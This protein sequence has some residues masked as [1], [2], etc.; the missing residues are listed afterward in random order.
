[1]ENLFEPCG[2]LTKTTCLEILKD[3]TN[4]WGDYAQALQLKTNKSQNIIRLNTLLNAKSGLCREDCGY[5]AQSKK[6]LQRLKHMDYYPK[7]K[8]FVKR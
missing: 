4:L 5:C 3:K 8:S 6:V 2:P 7:K 1:M